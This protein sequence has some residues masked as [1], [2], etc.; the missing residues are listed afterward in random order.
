MAKLIGSPL[1]LFYACG[2]VS[3]RGKRT[4]P[5]SSGP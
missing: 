3:V 4:C 1:V 2:L 5:L